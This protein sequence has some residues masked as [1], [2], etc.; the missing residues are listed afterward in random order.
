M[1]PVL[2]AAVERTVELGKVQ[3]PVRVAVLGS[4]VGLPLFES[5][6]ELGRD[7]TIARID[8]DNRCYLVTRLSNFLGG[9]LRIPDLLPDRDAPHHRG[10]RVS[11]RD[12]G[13]GGIRVAS[14]ALVA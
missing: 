2:D 14:G 8:G 1:R 12:R 13:A 3:A 10:D 9:A 4:T 11:R 6:E 5:L 7:R